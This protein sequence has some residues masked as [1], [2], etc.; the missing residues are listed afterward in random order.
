MVL[1]LLEI[2]KR[3]AFVSIKVELTYSPTVG[4]SKESILLYVGIAFIIVFV[5][6]VVV[7][8]FYYFKSRS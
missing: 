8:C 5:I 2:N 3:F 4:I 7:Y 6:I 1:F